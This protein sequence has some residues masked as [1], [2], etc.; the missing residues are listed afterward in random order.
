MGRVARGQRRQALRRGAREDAQGP[1]QE[2]PGRHRRHRGLHRGRGRAHAPGV[3]AVQDDEAQGRRQRRDDVPRAQGP[4]RL[5]VRVRRVLPRRD[6]R[7]GGARPAPA[8]RPRGR[9]RRPPGAGQD[10]QG[11]EAGPRGQAAEGRLRVHQLGQQAGD[12]DP[13][14]RAGDPAGAAPDGP[15]RR[16]PVR[17]LRPQRPLPPRDQPQQ[18]PQAAARPRRAGDHR[19]QREADAAGGGRRAVRQRPP[20][21]PGHRPGQP[22]AEVAVRH[23]QGQAGPLPPEP[24][25]QA[26]GLLGPV[27]D[28]RRARRCGCTSAVCRS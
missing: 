22:P 7:R 10:R 16:R 24:A 23:A 4:V 28:R 5:A 27:G 20:R 15:A 2:L 26:R 13:R 17:H 18:P 3:G 19:Q 9:G 8:G 14:G 11:P 25:R 6:G 12:D 21:P 1:A